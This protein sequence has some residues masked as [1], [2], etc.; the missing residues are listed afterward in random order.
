[1]KYLDLL[2]VYDS[3]KIQV[4]FTDTFSFNNCIIRMAFIRYLYELMIR[5]FIT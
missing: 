3:N 2:F 1:M 4:K 5:N